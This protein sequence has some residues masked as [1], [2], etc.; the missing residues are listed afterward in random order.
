MLSSHITENN[1][2]EGTLLTNARHFEIFLKIQENIVKIEEG[3]AQ[4][5]PTDIIAIVV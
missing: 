3:F 2:T 5:L 4:K 1:I